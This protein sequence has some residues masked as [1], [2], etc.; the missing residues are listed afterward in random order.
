[1][2]VLVGAINTIASLAACTVPPASIA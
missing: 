2:A 1:M